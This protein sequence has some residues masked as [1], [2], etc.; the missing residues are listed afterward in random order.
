M[1]G[2]PIKVIQEQIGHA[3]IEQTLKYMHLAPAAGSAVQ[4]LDEPAPVW[5]QDGTQHRAV[6]QV[7]ASTSE[8]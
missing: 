5:H 2:V 7:P 8:N 3:S 1:R 6:M 4:V